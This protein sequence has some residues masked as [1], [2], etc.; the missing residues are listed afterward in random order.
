MRPLKTIR[1][2]DPNT[3]I[4][5]IITQYY[6]DHTNPL[7]PGQE[8]ELERNML[9]NAYCLTHQHYARITLPKQR[10]KP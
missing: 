10:N 3:G 8:A 1:L 6:P 7:D 4:S 2:N 5:C 9:R